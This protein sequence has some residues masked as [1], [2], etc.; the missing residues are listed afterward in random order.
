MLASD[1]PAGSRSGFAFS[2]VRG[3]TNWQFSVKD[4]TT[5][6]LINTGMAYA[7]SKVYDMYFFVPPY[8]GNGTM[9]WRIDNLTDNTSQEG[10]TTSNL[11]AG[12]TALRVGLG[13]E[14]QTT[15]ARN[16]RMQRVYVEADR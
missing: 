7:A 10:S 6:N 4:G 14:T 8:P 12:S 3:D 1:D 2:T 9:Y 16:F 11:P 13:V 5:Q 15:A